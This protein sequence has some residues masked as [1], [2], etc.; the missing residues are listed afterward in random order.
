MTQRPSEPSAG[1]AQNRANRGARRIGGP[2][3]P[4]PGKRRPDDHGAP[5][6]MKRQTEKSVSVSREN[7]F[8]ARFFYLADEVSPDQYLY[9]DDRPSERKLR[10]GRVVAVTLASI[11]AIEA[12]AGFAV[13]AFGFRLAS[14]KDAAILQ[15]AKD[16][17][18]DPSAWAEARTRTRLAVDAK[19]SGIIEEAVTNAPRDNSYGDDFV[20]FFTGRTV[21]LYIPERPDALVRLAHRL[22]RYGREEREKIIDHLVRVSELWG[23]PGLLDSLRMIGEMPPDVRNIIFAKPDAAFYHTMQLIAEREKKIS[24]N[25]DLQTRLTLAN[26]ELAEAEQKLASERATLQAAADAFYPHSRACMPFLQNAFQCLGP[27]MRR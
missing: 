17:I 26:R 21:P 27:L 8:L 7:P 2:V 11:L 13:M 10:A 16:A 25:D 20:S 6:G 4:E 14:P 15:T 22:D 9:A 24:S 5:Q 18:P 1:G 12:F 19:V 3:D 23:Q